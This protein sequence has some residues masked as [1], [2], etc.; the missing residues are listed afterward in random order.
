MALQFAVGGAIIPFFTIL[1]R[2]RGLELSQI[3]TI[4]FWSSSTLLFFPFMCGM[5]SDRFIPLNRMFTI[6]N[7][8]VVVFLLWF[9]SQASFIGMMLTYLAFY[10]C[11]HPTF[12]LINALNFHHLKHPHE[13]FGK[14][15]AWGSMG[16]TI[17]SVFLF[18]YFFNKEHRD[19]EVT[20][21]V[22]IALAIGMTLCTFFLPHTP[23]AGAG[24]NSS[25]SKGGHSF[26][27]WSAAGK[28]L[29]NPDYL[30]ILISFFLISG[31]FTILVFYSPPYLEDK[32]VNRIWIGPIQCLGVVLEIMFFPSLR[33]F[34]RRWGYFGT[35]LFGSLCLVVRQFL[36]VFS[37]NVWLLSASYTLAGLVIVFYHIGGSI[38]VNAIAPREL[39]ATA[40]T[41]L[42]FFGSGLG[43]MFANWMVGVLTRTFPGD[44]H[45]VFLFSAILAALA[46]MVILL[47]GK[48]LDDAAHHPD[49]NDVKRSKQSFS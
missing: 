38:L 42:V 40:Q 10:A 36:Y 11:I 34:I 4:L 17:P 32:G 45:P 33:H 8:S 15:R 14:V 47:R 39:R 7:T 9:Q 26:K 21:L 24:K 41:L 31:S 37:E 6:L 43:P 18:F 30:T 19:M 44:L 3:S 27:Y 49:S 29:R 20:V 28:L 16:W 23:P 25:K 1:L 12:T 48:K 5:L 13:Q 22:G 2:D 46:A 35:V